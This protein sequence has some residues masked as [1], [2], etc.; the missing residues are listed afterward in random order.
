MSLFLAYFSVQCALISHGA[1]VDQLPYRRVPRRAT[2]T[3]CWRRAQ[4]AVLST[5]EDIPNPKW[6]VAIGASASDGGEFGESDASCG[7]VSNVIPVDFAIAGC[8]PPP[9]DL[10]RGL[11]SSPAYENK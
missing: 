3:S 2:R 9:V 7:A 1:A 8:P 6:V 4:Y 11:L 5:Y 10:L